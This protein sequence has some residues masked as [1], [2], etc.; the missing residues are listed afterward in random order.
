MDLW[1]EWLNTSRE[2][3]AFV[4]STGLASVVPWI[5]FAKFFQQQIFDKIDR[6]REVTLVYI[7]EFHVYNT[8]SLLLHTLGHAHHKPL[9][10]ICHRI[11]DPFTHFAHLWPPL[12]T[13]TLLSAIY[14]FISFGLVWSFIYCLFVFYIPHVSGIMWYLSFC[15]CLHSLS[16]VSSRLT[17]L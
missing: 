16:T 11:M 6:E 3:M 15:V 8:A 7:F 2:R 13:T 12:V 1:G 14:V 9:V 5:V 4:S 17:Y 10:S